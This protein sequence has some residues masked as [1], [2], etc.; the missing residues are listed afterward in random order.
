M[1]RDV[2]AL[3][4]RAVPTGP[5]PPIDVVFR[6]FPHARLRQERKLS[7]YMRRLQPHDCD[8]PLSLSVVLIETYQSALVPYG[9]DRLFQV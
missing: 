8:I 1:I 9:R 5:L 6:P 4:P 7:L 3:T 2:A